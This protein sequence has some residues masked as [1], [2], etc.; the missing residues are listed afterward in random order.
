MKNWLEHWG[1]NIGLLGL[2]EI[3]GILYTCYE[4]IEEPSRIYIF[5]SDGETE[6]VRTVKGNGVLFPR[7]GYLLECRFSIKTIR[8]PPSNFMP[9]KTQGSF[10]SL[11]FFFLLFIKEIFALNDVYSLLCSIV[12]LRNRKFVRLAF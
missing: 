11:S 8:F 6:F 3:V 7:N 2:V 12:F 9:I 1:N 5:N 10:S 4:K